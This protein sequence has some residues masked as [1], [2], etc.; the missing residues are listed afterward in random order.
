M[1]RNGNSK[2]ILKLLNEVAVEARLNTRVLHLEGE[3]IFGFAKQ[4]LD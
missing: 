1:S 2:W 4:M 3:T